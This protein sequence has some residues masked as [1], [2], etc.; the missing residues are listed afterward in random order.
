[1]NLLFIVDPLAK[2]KIEKDSTVAMMAAAT[3]RG[4]QLFACEQS[5]LS[6]VDGQ[7]LAD[8]VALELTGETPRW[9]RA[10]ALESQPLTSFDAVLMRKDPPFDMEYVYSTYLLE[11]A[12]RAGARVFNDPAA[13]R[14][15]NEKFSIT[16]DPG[17][18]QIPAAERAQA[19]GRHGWHVDLPGR[20]R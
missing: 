19:A 14:S 11:H 4:H 2:L 10:G 5:A 13:V 17:L 1:M 7:V 18:R 15:H 6:L 9:Y 16:E 8:A 3:A 12:A 20:A